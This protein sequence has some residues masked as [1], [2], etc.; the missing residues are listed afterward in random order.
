MLKD[1]I[2]F[3]SNDNFKTLFEHCYQRL[4]TYNQHLIKYLDWQT[5]VTD[6]MMTKI[7][8]FKYFKYLKPYL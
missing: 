7:C 6:Y 1:L 8:E 5:I 3:Y 4:T 2:K